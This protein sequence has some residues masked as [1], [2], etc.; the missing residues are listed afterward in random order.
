LTVRSEA[1]ADQPAQTLRVRLTEI[2]APEKGQAFGNRSKQH[3][4]DVD[5]KK[6]AKVRPQTIDRY[7][8]PLR[9]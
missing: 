1:Q 2:D 5:F 9:V 4:S 7:G 8:E 3:R 6:R